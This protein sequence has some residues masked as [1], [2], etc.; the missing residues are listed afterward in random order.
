MLKP[1]T[2][3]PSFFRVFSVFRGPNSAWIGNRIVENLSA[4]WGWKFVGVWCLDFGVSLELGGW[5]LVLLFCVTEFSP[6]RR[7][8]HAVSD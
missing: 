4:V 8:P 2:V 7:W 6:A 3:L 5:S 1:N